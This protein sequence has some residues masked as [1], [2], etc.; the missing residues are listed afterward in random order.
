[1]PPGAARI[2]LQR[3]P[4]QQTLFS[5]L[6]GKDRRVACGVEH[7]LRPPSGCLVVSVPVGRPSDKDRGDDQ[8]PRHA[9]YSHY[10]SKYVAVIAPFLE[11]LI[12]RLR[13]AVVRGSGE[14]LRDT[15]I[16]PRLKQFFG[17]DKT[18]CVPE[19]RRHLI[20]SALASIEGQQP[21]LRPYSA[22]FIGKRGAILIIRM[23]HDHQHAGP[24]MKLLQCDGERS[25]AAIFRNRLSIFAP[26]CLRPAQRLGI[27]SRR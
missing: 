11:G 5:N 17:A 13:E 19:I 26:V 23:G 4:R 10:V 16:P 14:I 8:W 12:K 1:M 27:H 18:Q 20:R 21:D 22:R 15:V 25:N 3:I 2:F 24:G 9:Y 7:L 6:L